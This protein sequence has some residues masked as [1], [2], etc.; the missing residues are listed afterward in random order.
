MFKF[1][2]YILIEFGPYVKR[3]LP[4]RMT[5]EKRA[6]QFSRARFNNIFMRYRRPSRQLRIKNAM[7]CRII[8]NEHNNA[9]DIM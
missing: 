1:T 8:H 4:S 6:K 2:S 3:F 5:T 7:E 9:T